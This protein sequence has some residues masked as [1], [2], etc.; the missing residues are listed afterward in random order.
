MLERYLIL[1]EKKRFPICNHNQ[2]SCP[3]YK[4]YNFVLCWR[5]TGFIIGD[6]IGYF[7]Y[8]KINSIQS[9]ILTVVLFSST[10]LDGYM[11]YFT[12]LKSSNIRRFITGIFS[13]YAFA[14][15]VYYIIG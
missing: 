13:G 12:R 2:K 10:F 7:I 8:F 5:C 15:L 14:L 6:I 1:Q 4:Q 11:N 9:L 3:R